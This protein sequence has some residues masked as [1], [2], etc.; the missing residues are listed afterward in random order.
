MKKLSPS[1]LKHQFLIAMPHMHDQN[2][3]QT[4][5]YIVEH[6]ANGAMGLVINRPQSL[7]LADVL[8]QL[9]P[10]LPAPVRCQ[11]I[12]IHS[13]GPVQTDRGFVLHP[14]GQIFQATVELGGI[15]LSTSQD[16]LFSIADGYGPDQNVIALGYAGWDAGQLDAEM[17][18]NAWLTCPFDPAI[19]FEVDSELRLDAAAARLGINLNLLSTQAGHA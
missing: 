4:L 11:H 14:S 10:E 16:V 5:T 3:A 2:F 12:P 8:E 1:Y 13:G 18:A 15:S 17:A 19:L 7:S 9:R 6:N